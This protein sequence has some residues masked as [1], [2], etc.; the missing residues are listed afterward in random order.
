MSSL[1]K[2]V[3]FIVFLSLLV[4]FS[5][6]GRGQAMG[7]ELT[8][9]LTFAGFYAGQPTWNIGKGMNILTGD[10]SVHKRMTEVEGHKVRV[11]IT[12]L[13]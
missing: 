6:T 2:L 7:F 3:L 13:D 11:V 12:I 1:N 10:P 4:V 5:I 9:P 8:G